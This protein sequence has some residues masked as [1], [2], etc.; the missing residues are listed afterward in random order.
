MPGSW[1]RRPFLRMALIAGGLTL[2]LS[3][4]HLHPGH[5]GIG[6]GYYSGHHHGHHYRKRHHHHHRHHGHHRRGG[7]R[8]HR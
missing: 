8:G 1:L 4:C 3:G 7:W 2:A 5:V 6:I